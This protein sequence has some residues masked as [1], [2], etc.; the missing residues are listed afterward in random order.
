MKGL[1]R[2]ETRYSV[3]GDVIPCE[4]ARVLGQE[5]GIVW[6]SGKCQLFDMLLEIALS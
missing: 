2:V 5:S 3:W 4:C 1:S 6:S